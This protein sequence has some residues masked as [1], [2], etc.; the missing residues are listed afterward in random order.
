MA[1]KVTG[2][3]GRLARAETRHGKVLARRQ[4]RREE[5]R[6]QQAMTLQGVER[7]A[8]VLVLP[9]PESESPEVRRH[10]PNPETEMTAMRVVMEH[11]RAQ[12]RQ[13]HDVHK[14]DLGY[15]IISLDPR[16]GDLR[17]IEIKGLA[18]VTGTVLLTPNERRV[19]EDRRDCYWLYVVTNCADEPQLKEPVRDPAR[20]QWRAV[21]KVQ[22]YWMQVDA[23]AQPMR[24]REN[25]PSYGGGELST[26]D[27]G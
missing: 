17:L 25:P 27:Q 7:L 12:N 21:K 1:K 24:I 14:V 2:A 22:H 10:R 8:S 19:A 11:E 5:L 6:R 20:F 4:R 15:D 26:D 3:E 18:G 13:V 16:S 9:H 23:I